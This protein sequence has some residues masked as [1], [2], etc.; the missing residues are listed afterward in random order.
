MEYQ[1]DNHRG[2]KV[3]NSKTLNELWGLGF[4]EIGSVTFES[5][6]YVARYATKKL[7]HGRDGTHN[8]TPIS[9]RSCK[10]AIGKKWIEKHYLDVFTS[11]SLI[12]DGG[13]RCGIPRYYEKWYK[14]K[15]PEAWRHYVANIKTKVV[16]EAI[17]KE[18]KISLE[19]KKANAKRSGLRGLQ[20]TKNQVR[21]KIMK[22]KFRTLQKNLKI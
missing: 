15:H 7:A 3:Y 2:D 22:E 21:E 11:G 1:Y 4:A 9:R 18:E 14:Q 12:L 6:G 16:D 13:I 8:Y 19:E 17:R 10:S 20:I 5:A